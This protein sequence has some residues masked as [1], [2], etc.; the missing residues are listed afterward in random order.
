MV[1]MIALRHN[2]LT[3]L[4]A[5]LAMA[6]VCTAM[7]GVLIAAGATE[8]GL[9]EAYGLSIKEL[10]ALYAAGGIVGG[11]IWGILR[12]LNKWWWGAAING[13]CAMLPFCWAAAP[14]I[15]KGQPPMSRLAVT[16]L[17]GVMGAV[18]GPYFKFRAQ[19]DDF[20]LD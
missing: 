4:L 16:L 9:E 6:V 13:Y 14:A 20:H 3:G 7:V 15:L 12:P 1:R 17:G 19:E 2:L 18:G 10:L 8:A 11:L 5:G